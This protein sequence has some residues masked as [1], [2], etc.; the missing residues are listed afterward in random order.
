MP[1][2]D[3][4]ALDRVDVDAL[5][6]ALE[7]LG[8]PTIFYHPVRSRPVEQDAPQLIG[9]LAAA[10]ERVA[11][12]KLVWA[13]HSD[14]AAWTAG[15]LQTLGAGS[16]CG[17]RQAFD[18]V[19]LRLKSTVGLLEGY[20]GGASAELVRL[21]TEAAAAFAVASSLATDAAGGEPAGRVRASQ[22]VAA[23]MAAGNASM[24]RAREVLS[25]ILTDVCRRAGVNPDEAA[26]HA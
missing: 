21:C 9:A 10:V 19:T 26:G 5:L 3:T 22:L 12:H 18:M 2:S 16:P 1:G 23:R 4:T 11:V 8:C 14:A 13:E 7:L 6:G 20:A 25:E 24:S 17:G 15:Y